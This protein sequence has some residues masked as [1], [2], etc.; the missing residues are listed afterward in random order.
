[1][2]YQNSENTPSTFDIS[3]GKKKV[4]ASSLAHQIEQ[5][6][7]ANN[8]YVEKKEVDESI[9]S[10]S[11]SNTPQAVKLLNFQSTSSIF[12]G[13]AQLLAWHL[14]KKQPNGNW[15][16]PVINGTDTEKYDDSMETGFEF[17]NRMNISKCNDDIY[18]NRGYQIFPCASECSDSFMCEANGFDE[19]A[20]QAKT[21][22]ENCDNV[23][24]TSSFGKS[25]QS[26]RIA[27]PKI[28]DRNECAIAFVSKGSEV[29]NENLDGIYN[30]WNLIGVDMEGSQMKAENKWL[31]KLSPGK[32]FHPKVRYAIYLQDDLQKSPKGDDILFIISMMIW[33]KLDL[34]G[35]VE[36]SKEAMILLSALE[37]NSKEES[38]SSSVMI[39][40]LAEA[41]EKILEFRGIS[42][43]FDKRALQY[44][45][46]LSQQALMLLNR[47][48]FFSNCKRS[49]K[50]KLRRWVKT[51]WVIHDLHS[52]QAKDFRCRWYKEQTKLNDD[53]D[54]VSFAHVMAVKEIEVMQMLDKNIE[55]TNEHEES[56]E[57]ATMIQMLEEIRADE[58]KQWVPIHG[59][60]EYFEG[61][62]QNYVQILTTKRL[63]EE[64]KRYNFEREHHMK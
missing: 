8:H 29:M 38:I 53:F 46:S 55:S 58:I 25:V 48:E 6:M 15:S 3:T 18:C 9:G 43:N 54:E 14:N 44:R 16:P 1:M 39:S 23:L 17:L 57:K 42:Q 21:L 36:K 64:R 7:P 45:I 47:C 40:N 34:L 27:A 51:K 37:N 60:D 20:T 41:R 52:Y 13:T 5:F 10:N 62:G 28:D 59:Y 2:Q 12:Y 4:S 11:V 33:Q 63:V 61:K 19:A 30:G 49:H 26:L 35:K 24:Y 31:P 32:L 50:Y 22:T 56:N